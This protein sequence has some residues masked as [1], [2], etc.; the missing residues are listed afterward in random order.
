MVNEALIS[1]KDDNSQAFNEL[2]NRLG[3]LDL[4]PLLLYLI[5]NTETSA[6]PHL[7]EQFHVMGSEG[8]LQVKTDSEKRDLIKQAINIHKYKGTKYAILRVL[9]MLS[10]NGSVK[11][12]FEY[13]GNPYCFKVELNFIERGLDGN[14]ISKLE[15]LINEYKNERSW[16]ESFCI[17]LTTACNAPRYGISTITGEQITIYPE[18][19]FFIWD[20]ENWDELN[21]SEEIIENARANPINWDE[22]TWDEDGWAFG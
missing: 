17:F 14:L 4:T 3:T 20:S 1:I 16:L 12:W 8:W 13:N 9:E 6:L 2:F 22:S 7:A 21:W 5:D 18:E 11:E 15:D 19:H 10:I